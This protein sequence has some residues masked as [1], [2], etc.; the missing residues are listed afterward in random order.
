ML[1]QVVALLLVPAELVAIST[2]GR[3]LH[4]SVGTLIATPHRA[5]PN[6]CELV[7]RVN[8]ASWLLLVLKYVCV[9]VHFVA[10]AEPHA[11][12]RIAS[13]SAGA[14]W[15]PASPRGS[16]QRAP[17]PRVSETPVI[18]RYNPEVGMQVTPNFYKKYKEVLKGG[19]VY[20]PHKP[21]VPKAQKNKGQT[22]KNK[23]QEQIA[24]QLVLDDAV[25]ND[26][27]GLD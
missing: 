3:L 19:P 27:A 26:P 1:L 25:G 21:D 6:Y 2:Y 10:A 7:W 14:Q 5:G 20:K 18:K 8:R 12:A 9:V 16:K 13:S 4:P 23:L 15:Q 11:A 22:G 24:A 17:Q